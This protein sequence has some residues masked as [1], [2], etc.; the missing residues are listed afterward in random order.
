[1]KAGDAIL[2]AARKQAEGEI[3]VHQANIEVY[4]TMPAGIGEHSDVTEAVIE[5]LNKMSAAYDRIEMLDMYF[6]TEE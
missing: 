3:A 1:M 5:E 2:L 6:K 4:R